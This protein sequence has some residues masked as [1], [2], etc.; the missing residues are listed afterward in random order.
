MNPFKYGA[1]VE[2]KNFCHRT[3]LVRQIREHIADK[4]NILIQG[5]RRIGK[6]SLIIESINTKNC[7]HIFVDLMSVKTVDDICKRLLQGLVELEKRSGFLEKI[8][9]NLKHLRPVVSIDP[10][11]GGPTLE[12]DIS[13][14]QKPDSILE[15]FSVIE[16]VCHGKKTVIVLDEFQDILDLE[17]NNEVLALMRSKIQRQKNISYVFCGSIRKKIDSIFSDISSPFFKS[18]I[19]MTIDSIPVDDYFHFIEQKFQIGKRTID[20]SLFEKIYQLCDGITGDI[21]Q[22]CEAIWSITS[23]KDQVRDKTYNKALLLLFSRE[24][25]TYE[26]AIG[27]ITAFQMRCLVALAKLGNVGVTSTAF[28]SK[29]GQTTPSSVKKAIQ[30]LADIRIIFEVSKRYRFSNP[31]FKM[32]LL[33]KRY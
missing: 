17:C 9:Q 15:T 12:L 32:W 16:S 11:T 28:I 3:A 18:A 2:G 7:R 33:H 23:Y 27:Q 14:P 30:R 22:F 21:Q 26:L 25:K 10:I 1:V 4:Q 13:T 6:T 31:F 24:Q 29:V 20:K 19:P 8:I 5:E